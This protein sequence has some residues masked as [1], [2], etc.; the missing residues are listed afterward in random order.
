MPDFLRA[1]RR[2]IFQK[3][4]PL[5]FASKKGRPLKKS[6]VKLSVIVLKHD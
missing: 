3:E 4:A 1:L 6:V 5:I 2:D